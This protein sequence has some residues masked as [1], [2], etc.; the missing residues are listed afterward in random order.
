MLDPNEKLASVGE[1]GSTARGIRP[2]VSLLLPAFNE[3]AI[4]EPN[5][6]R[7]VE[8]IRD[9]EDRFRWQIVI[10]DDGSAD[11]TGKIADACA[12]SHEAVHVVHHA[13]NRGLGE[14]IKTGVENSSG[15]YL[16][17]LDVDL[18]YDVGHI[19]KLLDE[20]EATD[21]DIVLA[22][23]YMKGGSIGNVPRLRRTLSIWANWFLSL[24]AHG[25]LSTLTCM[26]RG[27]KG[28]FA[29]ALVL[30]STSM[31]IMPETVYK[32]MIMRGHLRQIPAHLD[33]GAQAK[34]GERKSSMRMFRQIVGTLLSGFL[35]RPFM[36]FVLPG[37]LLLVFSLWVN[38]WMTIHFFD[39]LAVAPEGAAVDAFSW[40]V[41][42]AYA[43][44]PHTFIV[45]L[46]SLML[47]V[48]LISLGILALQS[49][50][51]FEELFYLGSMVGK[52]VRPDVRNDS[53]AQK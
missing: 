50:S 39:A 12:R 31:E 17:V 52:E 29:R 44:Y 8:Y 35:F 33:W 51:Y 16:I 40:A 22:S 13:H 32:T 10:I 7:I 37:L 27:Y 49:K 53:P 46:L 26:V 41:A 18:S 43:E 20:L 28:D 14:A 24:V 48:Q 34:G 19:G 5:V 42:Q 2:L 9:L 45:G 47:S 36:F 6:G 11:D 15:D 38:V 23:P 4:L 21:A 1:N 3:E 30:R 25:R